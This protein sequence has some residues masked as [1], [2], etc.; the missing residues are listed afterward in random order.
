MDNET[1]LHLPLIVQCCLFI[2]PVNIYVIGNWLGAGVQWILFRYQQTY[3]A[4]SLIP[5]FRDLGYVQLGALT[6]KSAIS[7]EISFIAT[8]CLVSATIVLVTATMNRNIPLGK[9]AA[10]ITIFGGFLFLVA[11]ATQYG[12]LFNGP[13][14][15][16]L[17]VGIPLMIVS[18]YL[19]FITDFSSSNMSESEE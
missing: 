8:L 15:F 16:V 18:G 2:L 6:G 4:D 5:F 1:R 11:D 7:A 19:A 17:P 14:G 12:I 10:I 3:V 13:A 9:I